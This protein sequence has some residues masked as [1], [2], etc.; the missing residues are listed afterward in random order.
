MNK[1]IKEQM[2]YWAVQLCCLLIDTAVMATAYLTAFLLRFDF[3]EPWWGWRQVA[4][5]FLTVW[6]VQCVALALFG[7]H[8]LIWRYVSAGDVPRF[9]G[10]I[11]FSTAS[12][13][14]LRVM[15]PTHMDLRPPYSIIFFNSVLAGG[16]LVGARL[17]WRLAVDGNSAWEAVT[18]G[19]V[20]RVL[21]V[22]AGSMGNLVARELRRKR[23]SRQA[24][25]GFLDDDPAKQRAR[26]QGYAVLGRIDALPRVVSKQAV[27][28]VIVSMV[29]VPR[30]V[31]RQVVRL[32]EQAHVPVRIVP[33]Y[34]ELID[35]SVTAS[36]IRNVDVADLLG[37][38]EMNPDSQAVVE[39]LGQK[40]V[41]V[42]GAGGTIGSE[43]VRQI[44]RTGPELLVMVER[45]EN[46]LYEIDREIR[47][48]G[49]ETP[50]VALL[51]DIGER[52]LMKA[53]FEMY[54]PQIVV[55]AAAYKHVPL[56]ENNPDEALKNNVLATRTLGEIAVD[57][58]VERFVFIS[59]DKAVNPVSVMGISKRF[60]EISLQD[61]N[62]LNKTRFSAV[63]FGNVLDSSG[64]VVPLF[65]EQ[66]LKGSA[67]TVTH[68]EMKRYFMTI[69]EAVSLVLQA[70]A[71][72]K[73]G[74]IFVLDMGESVKIV[75]L[76]EEMIALSGLRPYEDVP[77]VFTGI[78]PGEKLFEELDVSERSAY[79]T[80]HGRI[81]V[82]KIRDLDVKEVAEMLNAC[83]KLVAEG[84]DTE[85]AKVAIRSLAES[86]NTKDV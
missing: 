25:V 28:E 23:E 63:R 1:A 60:A 10:A 57:A 8:K 56:M 16:G 17:L 3:H 7:C 39:L 53:V 79:K 30:E 58:G 82:S 47:K 27:D 78:R 40:R 72:A 5:S 67:V 48:L 14:V 64:S 19:R 49:T 86:Q 68:P 32:C 84:L 33:G 45:S 9:V 59:T 76:A 61:L 62:R 55:H 83:R 75:E 54:R 38:A 6:I 29:N 65:R 73:G 15:L 18:K 71:L 51:A 77:I 26:I 4:F 85:K 34:H 81:Y 43:L 70:A 20:R 37:R 35:G 11:A 66:I 13:T 50:V 69:F 42:T 74:E 24:V 12:L 22:G 52:L 46:A 21:L 41:L 36:K 31:I 2:S 44:L 80:G